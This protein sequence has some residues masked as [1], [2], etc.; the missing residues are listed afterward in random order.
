MS[1]KSLSARAPL[2]V[3]APCQN[4]APNLLRGC[5]ASA[6]RTGLLGAQTL[7]MPAVEG[8][9]TQSTDAASSSTAGARASRRAPKSRTTDFSALP[10]LGRHPATG[11]SRT[12]C[13]KRLH[14]DS[15]PYTLSD[16]PPQLCAPAYRTPPLTLSRSAGTPPAL[17]ATARHRPRLSV[18]R[19]STLTYREPGSMWRAFCQ[20]FSAGFCPS[21][22]A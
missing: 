5:Q 13:R 14:W 8:N 10:L 16:R 9:T 17:A 4:R 7:P 11:D 2:P 3:S 22:G 21:F 18:L 20:G 6:L 12:R 1:R 15:G 19:A